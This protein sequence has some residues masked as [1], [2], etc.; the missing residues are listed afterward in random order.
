MKDKITV[1]VVDDEFK[2]VEAIAA[3]LRSK[4]YTVLTAE[5]G[6]T[7][8][9]IFKDN[10]INFVILDLMLPDLSG[11]EVCAKIRKTSNVP[12]IMLTAKSQEESILN[13]LNIGADD[14]VV[15]PFSIKQLY[16]R[17]E[18]VLR[19][20]MERPSAS[21]YSWNGGDLKINFQTMTV[22]KQGREIY[23][24]SSEWKILSAL[25]KNPQTVFTRDM[26]IESAFGEDIDSFDRVID[27]HVKNIR[28]KIETD[29]K[30]PLYILT[31]RG[32]GYKFGG[33][34]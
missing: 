24:T 34:D 13:G 3:F 30:N 1:L 15:K 12:V 29:T 10:R 8:L 25:V 20:S 27:T 21:I 28:A 23:L 5:S 26:L 22:E 11:E 19:R 16:A 14:Y 7:A 2:I 18:A 32:S 17:M 33:K 31:V 6:N 4:G 9:Q